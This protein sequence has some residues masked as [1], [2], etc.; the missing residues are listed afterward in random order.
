M[1][2][3][4]HQMLRDQE[5]SVLERALMCHHICA[6]VQA[7]LPQLETVWAESSR[8]TI[9]PPCVLPTYVYTPENTCQKVDMLTPC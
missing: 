4:V 1:W 8:E 2:L 3:L 5:D 6:V 9:W 7:A